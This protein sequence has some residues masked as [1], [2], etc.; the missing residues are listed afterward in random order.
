LLDPFS[1]HPSIRADVRFFVAE[2]EGNRIGAS[3]LESCA[4]ER[5][6]LSL[7]GQV[8]VQLNPSSIQFQEKSLLPAADGVVRR[9]GAALRVIE[10][11]GLAQAALDQ[12]IE[13]VN[14]RQQFG[15]SLSKFQVIQ[16]SLATMAAQV[17]ALEGAA[18]IAAQFL[19]GDLQ[20]S[21]FLAA[22]KA[23]ADE[24]AGI[25][26][27]LA[28]QAHGAIGFTEEYQ[29]GRITRALWT[30]RAQFGGQA[31][32]QEMVATAVEQVGADAL[33]QLVTGS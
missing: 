20:P 15:R 27:A 6:D 19:V 3:L 30:A 18:G 28:H 11:A 14:V 2:A 26:A 1:S 10:M 29:L 7:S 4:P 8:R 31:Y 21:V 24:S 25:V 12:T 17:A 33:W 9:A 5:Q 22:A 23:R 32:W 13:Y 16:H